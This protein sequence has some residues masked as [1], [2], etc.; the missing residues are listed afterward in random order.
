MAFVRQD[1]FFISFACSFG[2][3]AKT[4]RQLCRA[5]QLGIVC[6]VKERNTYCVLRSAADRQRLNNITLGFE[7]STVEYAPSA[8]Y[9]LTGVRAAYS[10]FHIAIGGPQPLRQTL[11]HVC[12]AE[13]PDRQ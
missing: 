10:A 7:Q 12:L 5:E 9:M 8:H 3:I 11:A 4:G 2:W 6:S 1:R 13:A